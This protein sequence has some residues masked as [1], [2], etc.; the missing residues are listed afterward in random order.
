MVQFQE[1]TQ[2]DDRRGDRQSLP[3]KILSATARGLT[4]TTAVDCHLK[5]K[6]IEYD[7]GL[8]KTYCLTV[9]L[10]KMSS[11]HTLIQQILESHELNDD[12]HF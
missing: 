2:A 10:Q 11:I 12:A 4:S 5:V 1:N 3:H 8:T 9:S 7:V 6:G